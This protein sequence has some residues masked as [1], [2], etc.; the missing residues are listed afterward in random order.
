M[1]ELIL[2]VRPILE[3]GDEPFE[4]IM[5]AVNS[6]GNGEVLLLIAPFEPKP[7]FRVMERKGVTYD[8]REIGPGE[9]HVRLTRM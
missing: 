4:Q 1:S 7:L 9:Y 2:D 6:L 3:R 8:C 5:A